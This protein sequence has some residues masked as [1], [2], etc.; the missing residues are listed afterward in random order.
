MHAVPVALIGM[1]LAAGSAGAVGLKPAAPKPTCPIL[2][3]TV[4]LTNVFKDG[5][6]YAM[7]KP[8]RTTAY[9]GQTFSV[10]S[11]TQI[12]RAI[13]RDGTPVR[14]PRTDR[15]TDTRDAGYDAIRLEGK[16]GTFVIRNNHVW[17]SPAAEA[18]SQRTGKGIRWG[19]TGHG[20]WMVKLDGEGIFNPIVDSPLNGYK[21]TVTASPGRPAI[22]VP[23]A[24]NTRPDR[25]LNELVER[26]RNAAP[27]VFTPTTPI[28]VP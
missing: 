5:I 1:V 23:L 3:A 10:T 6:G 19:R 27:P 24:K 12:S 4:K 18:D 13:H 15:D 17:G 11:A 21:V 26:P 25:S 8:P 14:N 20:R 2:G 16:S 28:Q 9:D 7:S 22:K